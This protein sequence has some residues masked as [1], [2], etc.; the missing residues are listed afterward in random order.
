MQYMLGSVNIAEASYEDNLRLIKE[1]LQQLNLY[2]LAAQI[3]LA[4]EMIIAFCGDQLTIDRLRG[5]FRLR[6]SDSNSFDRLDWMVLAFGWLH[7]MMALGN[8]IH[9]QYLGTNKDQAGLKAAFSTLERKGLQ[10]T[11]TKGLFYHHLDEALHHI[12]EAHIQVDWL[13]VSRVETL[14]ELRNKKPE[15]LCKLAERL[16]ERHASTAAMNRY[17]AQGP[18]LIDEAKMQTIACNR[19]LLYYVVLDAAIKHGDVGIMEDM[20]P[21]L[22]FQLLDGKNPKYAIEV[23]ELLQNLHKEWPPEVSFLS[24]TLWK[25][26]RKLHPAIPVI[27]RLAV[28]MEQQFGTLTRGKRHTIPKKE[29]DVRKLRS[30]FVNSSYHTYTPGRKL[31]R[32]S[33]APDNILKGSSL[34]KWA[35][36]RALYR[37]EGQD[38]ELFSDSS[39]ESSNDE[40]Q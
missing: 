24:V 1:W 23:L 16:V 25:Y 14:Q 20:L 2:N 31:D 22:L 29:G 5:L 28:Y 37:S 17:F 38:F 19:D 30:T 4:L 32:E 3:K 7:L 35:G 21:I 9:K 13:E 12:L 40:A 15:E 8:S 34:A 11:A 27:K 18:D 26:L 10:S 6:A 39:D 36:G 33:K